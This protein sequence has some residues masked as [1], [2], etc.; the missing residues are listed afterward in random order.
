CAYPGGRSGPAFA[1]NHRVVS[2]ATRRNGLRRRRLRSGGKTLP[3]LARDFPRLLSRARRAWP[4]AGGEGR[5]ERRCRIL[6][7]RRQDFARPGLRRRARRFA[8]DR[9]A[10][11]RGRSAI[12]LVR[13]DGQDRRRGRAALQP[14]TRVL[15]RRPR[16][17][18]RRSLSTRQT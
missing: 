7:T 16:F 10:E 8:P 2:L 4:G 15:L 12:R 3:R 14:P 18:T 17:E 6:R 5:S 11:E 9:R 13:T 1:R